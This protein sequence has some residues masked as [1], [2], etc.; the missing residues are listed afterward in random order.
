MA[1]ILFLVFIPRSFAVD[2]SLHH[3]NRLTLFFHDE[4]PKPDQ[5]YHVDANH[6][7]TASCINN[8]TRVDQITR[9]YRVF[10]VE[11]YAVLGK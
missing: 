3:S 1:K 8:Q 2:S 4:V 5:S 7:F 10:S 11:I 9:N 6:D